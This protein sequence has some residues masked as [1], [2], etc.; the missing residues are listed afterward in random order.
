METIYYS[1][2]EVVQDRGKKG[3]RAKY[4]GGSWQRRTCFLSLFCSSRKGS[5]DLLL[6]VN[7]AIIFWN[8]CYFK[9]HPFPLD[10]SE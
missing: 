7:K 8:E 3:S 4:I 9:A 6:E 2:S 1:F 10:S 5:L